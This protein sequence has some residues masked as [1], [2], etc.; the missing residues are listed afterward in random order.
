M[1]ELKNETGEGAHGQKPSA[2]YALF[3]R[4]I[5]MPPEFYIPHP[6]MPVKIRMKPA[7]IPPPTLLPQNPYC[8]R[9]FV[10]SPKHCL[11]AEY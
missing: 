10:P 8:P 7:R 3:P 4:E 5:L 2:F 1:S 9:R 6:V 11:A